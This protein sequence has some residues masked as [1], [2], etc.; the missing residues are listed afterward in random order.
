MLKPIM[1]AHID[2]FPTLLTYITEAFAKGDVCII[3]CRDKATQEMS[4][5]LALV[6][7]NEVNRKI[8]FYP[9]ARL[10]DQNPM[11]GVELV[12]GTAVLASQIP[13]AEWVKRS[14]EQPCDKSQ[15]N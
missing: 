14:N 6:Q 7:V 3:E 2:F 9:I 1:G 11:E 4:R 12:H 5:V 15:M 8:E 10:Y 13:M